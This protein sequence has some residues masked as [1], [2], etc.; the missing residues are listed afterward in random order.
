MA[1]FLLAAALGQLG[2]VKESR[3]EAEAGLTLNSTFTISSF[4]DGAESDNPI[5]LKQRTNVY[6]GL[7][8]AGIPETTNPSLPL[9]CTRS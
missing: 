9:L 6:E 5:F 8:L 2:R 4:R 7:R 3:A 1:H